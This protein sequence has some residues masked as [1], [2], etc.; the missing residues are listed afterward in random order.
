MIAIMI[1]IIMYH[2]MIIYT[3]GLR[4][5][6]EAWETVECVLGAWI[7]FGDHPLKLER[8]RE[9]K[10]G[11]CA[12][13]TRTHREVQAI[14]FCCYFIFILFFYFHVLCFSIFVFI[15]SFTMSEQR[16]QRS[17]L[18]TQVSGLRKIMKKYAKRVPHQYIYI[19][20]YYNIYIYIYTHASYVYRHMS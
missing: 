11:P 6:S 8:R 19:Y 4:G 12:R 10:H 1:M 3:D 18:P 15:I 16:P 20:I 2:D 5:A 14:S 17:L 9:D 13:M 7:P